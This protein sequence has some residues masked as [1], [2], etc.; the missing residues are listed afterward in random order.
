MH[1]MRTHTHTYTPPRR[2][3]QVG[4]SCLLSTKKSEMT[5]SE[6]PLIKM[7]FV[8]YQSMFKKCLVLYCSCI[9][10][11]VCVPLY[12]CVSHVQYLLPEYLARGA[13]CCLNKGSQSLALKRTFIKHFH[14]LHLFPLAT[15]DKLGR[16]RCYITLCALSSVPQ[17]STHILFL[18]PFA[19]APRDDH[20]HF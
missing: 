19:L 17:G 4:S 1:L 8:W 6:C 10:W 15:T 20:H 5:L 18:M 13:V 2:R 7:G 12:A 11:C 16:L 9:Y 14:G 3:L